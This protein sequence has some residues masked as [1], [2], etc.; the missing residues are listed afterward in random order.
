MKDKKFAALSLLFFLLFF[1]GIVTVAIQKPTN[2]ILRAKSVNP[3]PLKSFIIVFPQI[4]TIG[5]E[6]GDKNPPQI[7]V[8]V[9]IRDESGSVLPGRS[10]Q[11]T[12]SPAVNIKPADTVSTDSLGMAQFFLSS[13]EKGTV[14][15][16]ATDISSNTTIA[17]SPTVDFTE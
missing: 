7:K 9:Y 2:Q 14:K 13:S 6:T 16:T 10:V 3:S 1:A 12:T 17:N 15:L 5:T 11:L 8:S 4:G